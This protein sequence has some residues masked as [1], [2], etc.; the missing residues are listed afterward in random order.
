MSAM[1]YETLLERNLLPDFLIRAGI[2]RLLAQRLRDESRGGPEEI[3][4]RKNDFTNMLKQSPVAIHTS[5]ANEQHYEVPTAFYRFVLGPHMKY[6]SCRFTGGTKTLEEGEREMLEVT[7]QRA[8]LAD[9]Q[10]ILELGCGWGSLTLFM[11]GKYPNARVTAVSNSRTQK[12]YIETQARVRGLKN[13][14]VIT[15]DMR[16]FNIGEQF[17]RVV[18]VE[19]FEHMRNYE[20]LLG[21]V[22]SWLK[23]DGKLFV[24]IFVHREVAYPFEVTGDNPST[25]L[26]AGDWMA[27]YFFTGGIMPSADL[28]PRFKRDVRLVEQWAEDG[29]HYERTCNEWLKNMDRNKDEILPLFRDVYGADQAVKWWVY[30]RVFFMSCAELFGYRNGLEW[31]VQHYLFEPVAKPVTGQPVTREPVAATA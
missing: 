8:R 1:W 10:H 22:A 5:E 26:R 19:M 15:A 30:W 25:S 3:E 28:L 20:T 11:A 6:S 2:R 31:R 21:R 18:S 14:R 24:H 23:P 12:E 29:T 9:N 7:C 13:V 4:K 27:R 16:D 17:D